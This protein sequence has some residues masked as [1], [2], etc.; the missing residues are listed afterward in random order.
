MPAKVFLMAGGGTGG[1]V[2][3]ALAVALSVPVAVT[4]VFGVYPRLLFQLPETS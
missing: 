3:P 1:H 4:L 2:I